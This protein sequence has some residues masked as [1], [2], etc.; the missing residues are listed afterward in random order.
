MPQPIIAQDATLRQFGQSFAPAFSL[1]QWKYFVTVLLGLLHCD[2]AHTLCGLLRQV[3][4]AVTV[5]GLSRFLAQAPWS[6]EALTALRQARFEAQVALP[7]A[8][9][10]AQQRAQREPRRGRPRQTVV[11]GFLIMDDSTH[12]K[13][14]ASKMEG[15]GFHYSGSDHRPMP[16]HSLFQSLYVLL[17]HRLPLTPR[18]YRRKA[19]CMA[20]GVPFASKVDLAEQQI[21]TF[22]P[23][24]GTHTHVLVDNW[25]TCRRIWRA[26][27]R[28][29]W[30]IT[31]GLKS[32]RQMRVVAPDGQRSWISLK[33]VVATLPPESF[34]AVVWPNQDGGHTVYA[35]LIRTWVKKL[36][37]CQVL[38]VKPTADAPLKDTRFWATSRLSDSLD[39]VVAAAAQ[40]WDIEVLFADSKELMGSDQY[41]V[42]TAEAIV[43]FW[44][45]GLCLYQYLDEQRLRLQEQDGR[46]RTLGEVRAW[47]REQHATLLLDW[48]HHRVQEGD[49]QEQIRQRLKPA[50]P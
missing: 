49:S 7:V 35:H 39:Q 26:T 43:R 29:G 36:G 27:L 31:G 40:R 28:R 22:Q 50:V 24:P 45:L 4:V 13:R 46:R 6:V 21:M 12:V 8:H 3:A 16:G 9:A 38:I 42:R 33:D 48:I 10:H 18:L 17:G 23:P 19:V 2:A 20:E 44:A 14:F 1:P 25:Y 32:N 5:S 37:P 47:V 15:L 30:D 11:T 34:Q 41:Q